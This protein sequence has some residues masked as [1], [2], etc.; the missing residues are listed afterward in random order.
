MIPN[1]E[2]WF[3]GGPVHVL[4]IGLMDKIWATKKIEPVSRTIL[5]RGTD[6]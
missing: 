4:N 5:Q 2:L 1:S 3:D 6:I